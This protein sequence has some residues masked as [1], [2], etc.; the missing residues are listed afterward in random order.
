MSWFDRLEK[1]SARERKILIIS[2]VAALL[3][4][5]ADQWTKWYFVRNFSYGQSVAIIPGW[6][7]FT[8][9]RNIG[10][11]W[12]ILSGY[13]WFLL[14]LGVLAGT[15][16]VCF[17]RKL[18]EA[19]PER[20]IALLLCLSG[21]IGNSFDR[22]FHGSVVDFIH[23]HYQNVWHFPVFNIADMAICTG[24]G[25]YMLSCLFRK[26]PEGEK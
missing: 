20:Y 21:I 5:I 18:T 14:I 16:I 6:L 13:V 12:S 10:A 9:V 25:V 24:V 8:S 3:L 19:F 4:L 22:A 17:F 15:A 26:T 11:A 7:N 1:N 23:V 2:L